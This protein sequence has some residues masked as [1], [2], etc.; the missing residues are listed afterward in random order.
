M[1]NL[2]R[3]AKKLV[4][5]HTQNMNPLSTA[6]QIGT[7]VKVDPL[8]ISWGDGILIKAD[9]LFLPK[10]YLTGHLIPNRYKDTNGSMVDETLT[11][12]VELSIGDRVVVIPDQNYKMFYLVDVL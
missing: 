4:E 2:D 11:W 7:V 3:L 1:S 6:P 12:K 10:L 5:M 8:E 9:K